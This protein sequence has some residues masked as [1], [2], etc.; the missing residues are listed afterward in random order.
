M[1]IDAGHTREYV[2]SV[3]FPMSSDAVNALKNLS[4]KNVVQ[5]VTS[6]FIIKVFFLLT[7]LKRKLIQ[8]KKQLN[9]LKL[10]QLVLHKLL[11]IVF[12]PMNHVLY[13]LNMNMN[14]KVQLFVQLYL[15][16]LVLLVQR[17]KQKCFTLL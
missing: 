7:T 12:Q 1:E 8:K 15:S 14:M 3:L 13:S 6:F 11:L 2:H 5:L 17:L 16:I 10:Y 4:S 9:Y